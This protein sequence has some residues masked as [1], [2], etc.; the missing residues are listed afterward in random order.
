MANKKGQMSIE[1]DEAAIQALLMS[2]GMDSVDK[3]EVLKPQPTREK[4]TRI[5]KYIKFEDSFTREYKY[6]LVLKELLKVIDVNFL[7]KLKE[8]NWLEISYSRPYKQSE[9]GPVFFLDCNGDRKRIGE[10]NSR[11]PI[12]NL[13]TDLRVKYN[14]YQASLKQVA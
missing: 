13:L 3:V 4:P 14:D 1:K 2:C 6:S 10:V 11:F 8:E 5:L 12:F 9:G 7:I